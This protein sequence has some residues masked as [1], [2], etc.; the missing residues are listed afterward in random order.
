MVDFNAS[1]KEVGM[2]AKASFSEKK[3]T[4]SP[5]QITKSYFRREPS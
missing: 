1:K 4:D 2:D 3:G 5:I